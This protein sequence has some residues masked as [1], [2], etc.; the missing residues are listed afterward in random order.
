MDQFLT[1][2]DV[3][4][5]GALIEKQV[6]TPD[7]YPLSLNALVAA[8]NQ[9]SNRH[10]VVAFDEETVLAAI[11]RLR[12]ASLVR[13]IQRIDSR[14]TKYEHLTTDV[15]DVTSNELG[16]LCVLMLRGPNTVGEL[17]TRSERLAKF[18]SL[19]EVETTLTD[20]MEREKN[21]LVV[22]LPRKAGQKEVRFAHLLSGDVAAESNETFQSPMPATTQPMPGTTQP[23]DGR[24]AALEQIIAELQS[25]VG[26]LRQQLAEFRKQFE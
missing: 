13:G 7:N 25:E 20:L 2:A 10:P 3:R 6:T 4:V 24:V 16:I 17:R 15:L 18:D 9:S 5:L 14:V 22:R 19:A 12:R 1:D 26:D 21:A 8:C 23:M 11:Q